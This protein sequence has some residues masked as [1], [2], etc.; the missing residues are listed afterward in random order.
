MCGRFTYRLTW[1]EI[2]KLYRLTLDVT[3]RHTQA[4][5]HVCPTDPTRVVLS[6]EGRPDLHPDALGSRSDVVEQAVEGDEARLI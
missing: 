6:Q 4:R 5:C 1:P 3:A 2:V